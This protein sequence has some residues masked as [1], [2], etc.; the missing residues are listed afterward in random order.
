MAVAAAGG[1][2]GACG[3]CFRLTPMSFNNSL[4]YNQ[5]MTFMIVDECPASAT[6][7]VPFSG[8]SLHCGQCKMGDMNDYGKQWHF[9]IA[10][11]AMNQQQ[12]SQFFNGV[13]DGQ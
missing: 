5:A 2:G 1:A 10:V 13:T 9:D 4:L 8:P 12:F 11:D 7:Q 6:P 3:V